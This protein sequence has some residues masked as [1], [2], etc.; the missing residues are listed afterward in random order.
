MQN[1]IDD[2]G[3]LALYSDI[4]VLQ[5]EE[6]VVT[7]ADVKDLIDD[8]IENSKRPTAKKLINKVFGK[9]KDE[10]ERIILKEED[11]R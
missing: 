1:K 8:A 4:D 10:S 6:K 3:I 11:F 5:R 2:M 7:V 9:N